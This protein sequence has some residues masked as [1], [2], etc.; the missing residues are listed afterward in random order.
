MNSKTVP[1]GSVGLT[2]AGAEDTPSSISSVGPLTK[3]QRND[4]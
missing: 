4:N 3:T 1:W 2:G